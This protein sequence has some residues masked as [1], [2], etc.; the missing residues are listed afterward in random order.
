MDQWVAGAMEASALPAASRAAAFVAA[1]SGAV[2]A[3]LVPAVAIAVT[4]AVVWDV[5]YYAAAAAAD[6]VL[7]L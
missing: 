4:V 3:Y 7:C 1:P 2:A 5:A 6:R